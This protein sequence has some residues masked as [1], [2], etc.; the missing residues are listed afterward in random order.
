MT[1]RLF[2]IAAAGLLLGAAATAA[3]SQAADPAPAP[4]AA[5]PQISVYRNNAAHTG[6]TTELMPT[7]VSLLWRHTTQAAKGN[8]S[9]P[10]SADG[11][12]Y[13]GSGPNV[14]AVS[15]ADGTQKWK[16]PAD[17]PATGNFESTATLDGGALYIGADDGQFYK[18]DAKTGAQVWVRKVGGSVRS[19]PI[20]SGG[21]VYF[22]SADRSC[23]ALS[24]DSGQTVWSVPTEGPITAAPTLQGAEVV[25]ASSD[26]ILYGLN[27]KKG[28]R[29]WTLHLPSDPSPSPPI[30]AD[31]SFF[32]GAGS[33]LY[34]LDARGNQTGRALDLGSQIVSQPT[35]GAGSVFVVTQSNKV[36]A[37][38]S[39]SKRV[40][41]TASIGSPTNASPLLAGNLLLVPTQHGI[42]YGFDAQTG[43]LKW[44]Y[45]VQAV[46]TQTQ[47]KY[48]ATDIASAPVWLGGVLYVLSDDGTLSAFRA[49]AVDKVPPQILDITP[50]PGAVVAGVRIP[51]GARVFDDGSGLDPAS[52]RFLIDNT[53]ASLVKYDPSRNGVYIDLNKDVQGFSDRPAAD[54][55]H[56]ASIQAKDWRGNAVTKTWA[57]VVDNTLNPPG[58]PAPAATFVNP[59]PNVT[60]PTLTPPLMPG[61]VA[62][63]P[64][65]GNAP[66]DADGGVNG[67]P[68]PPPPLDFPPTV[69]TTAPPVGVIPTPP[70]PTP[71][72]GGNPTPVPP[73]GGA[74]APP[75]PAPPAAPGG[76]G[77]APAPPAAPGAPAPPAAPG[78]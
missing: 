51:Y 33:V 52:V 21:L 71:P 38:T 61:T 15:A 69:A 74:P 12:V 57:F 78:G 36:Y 25:F 44:Q 39:S 47:P 37:V 26:N 6:Y 5:G 17:A 30:Y 76:G 14:Y 72:G 10:V 13:F 20:V 48:E 7:P 62:T 22:G 23:Y 46:G 60:V 3:L 59:S 11:L 66:R 24:A 4:A 55:L 16:F 41:W 54:G 42:L 31:G 18:I 73:V 56:Q 29:V 27:A 40:R 70:T 63:V 34:S 64:P 19:S 32:V 1:P 67:G 28:D 43:A 45:V 9:S 2:P 50:A 68:P 75:T 65:G 8:P 35:G 58:T 49:N 77:G 53:P